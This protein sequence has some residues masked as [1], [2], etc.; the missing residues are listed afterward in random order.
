MK[1]NRR[2]H[3]QTLGTS[4]RV[5]RAIIEPVH[6]WN[7]RTVIKAHHELGMKSYLPGSTD[8][9]PDQIGAVG[10]GH[11]IDNRRTACLSLKFSL[12]DQS[13]RTVTP[14]YIENRMCG[15]NEPSSIVRRSEQAGKAGSRVETRPA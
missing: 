12:Q 7:D 5:D 6:P 14:T 3:D 4:N 8:H 10:R 1:F 13:A 11:E 9:D 2:P 15:C